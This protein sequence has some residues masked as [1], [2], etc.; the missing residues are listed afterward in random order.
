MIMFAPHVLENLGSVELSILQAC[1]RET[2]ECLPDS[3]EFS[4]RV[5]A[6][7]I[8]VAEVGDI[9]LA[10]IDRRRARGDAYFAG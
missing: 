2:L 10:E 1:T 3:P 8:E 7:R 5:G 6:T 9:L 4:T